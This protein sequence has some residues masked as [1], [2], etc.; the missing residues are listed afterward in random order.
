MYNTN[1]I[2]EINAWNRR[3]EKRGEKREREKE[4]EKREREREEVIN[5]ESTDL[6]E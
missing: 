5:D 4:K 6:M 1:S 3:E 2:K